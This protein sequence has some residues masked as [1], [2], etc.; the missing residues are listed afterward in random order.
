MS[1]IRI[2]AFAVDIDKTHQFIPNLMVHE[3]EALLFSDVTKFK[4]TVTDDHN[5]LQQLVDI[6]NQFPTPEH[7]N[8]S[9]ETAHSKRLEKI[10]PDYNKLVD[11]NLI[12]EAI[13]M[14]KIRQ[15]CHHF[16][17]WINKLIELEV[18]M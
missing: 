1:M 11:G 13:G 16:D 12:A 17:A 9:Y 6:R 3:F 7:I 4:D 18:R 15:E 8:D 14:N 5:S 10:F 2:N